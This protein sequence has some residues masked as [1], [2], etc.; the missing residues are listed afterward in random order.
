MVK[1]EEK[2]LTHRDNNKL[3]NRTCHVIDASRTFKQTRVLLE[4]EC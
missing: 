3:P 4:G 1:D 2:F